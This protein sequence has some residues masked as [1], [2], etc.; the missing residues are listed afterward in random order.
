V[1]DTAVSANV[2]SG[3]EQDDSGTASATTVSSGGLLFVESGA[4]ATAATILSGG[5]VVIDGGTFSGT[6]SAG[7]NEVL[8]IISAGATVSNETI[9]SGLIQSVFLAGQTV[10]ISVASAGEQDI[11]G[12]TTTATS[13]TSGGVQYVSSGTASGTIVSNGGYQD[14]FGTTSLTTVSSGGIEIVESGA[15]ANSTTVLSG[16]EI[17][18][19][20]GATLNNPVLSSGA[21]V[22]VL[23]SGGIFPGAAVIKGGVS[24]PKAAPAAATE[25]ASEVTVAHLI[26]AMASFNA[27]GESHGALFES[28]SGA[29][30]LDSSTALTVDRRPLLHH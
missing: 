1:I 28:V 23:S 27:G 3:G 14:D 19:Y 26:Q 15:T 21:I 22:V 8:E 13:I 25:P 17:V 29:A 7:A 4:I 6:V 16:G 5:E 18:E 24:S 11:S 9:T 2:L 12:G 20:Y 10:S 30:I